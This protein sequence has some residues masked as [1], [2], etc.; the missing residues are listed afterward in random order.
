M[1]PN[2]NGLSSAGA[3]SLVRNEENYDLHPFLLNEILWN[4]KSQKGSILSLGTHANVV[5]VGSCTGLS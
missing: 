3:P 1:K 5:F 4:Y 2:Q